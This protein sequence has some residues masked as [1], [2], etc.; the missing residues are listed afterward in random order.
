MCIRVID[1]DDHG[2]HNDRDDHDVQDDHGEDAC[3][4]SPCSTRR[5]DA[6]PCEGADREA[7]DQRRLIPHEPVDVAQHGATLGPSCD[8]KEPLVPV[9][10]YSSFEFPTST[11]LIEVSQDDHERLQTVLAGIGLPIQV[12]YSVAD[13]A[14]VLANFRINAGLP[15]T[16]EV[17][18]A[19]LD[20]I[21]AQRSHLY[22]AE[23]KTRA[24]RLQ[25]LLTDLGYAID[26]EERG[27]REYGQTNQGAV[28]ALQLERGWSVGDGRMA[29]ELHDAI[30]DA[31]LWEW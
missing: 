22:F 8:R 7:K 21:N 28:E 20:A 16:G 4:M 27:E 18:A 25:D 15:V 9:R 2:D 10:N 14:A 13:T 3:R 19:T 6:S 1:T 30:E 24:A 17:D 5:L 12:G 29:Q 23:N 26:P 31:S 11:L